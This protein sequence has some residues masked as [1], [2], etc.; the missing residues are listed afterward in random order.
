MNVSSRLDV[1]H[2]AAVEFAALT[3]AVA[4]QRALLADGVGAVEDPVLPGGEATEDAR[5]HRLR[6]GET[7]V[8][9]EAGHRVGREASALLQEDAHLVLPIDVV[10]G[11]GDETKPRRGRGVERLANL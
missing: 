10:E 2:A 5:L 7:Q 9:L 8:G 3:G 4:F 6:P 1:S 11:E